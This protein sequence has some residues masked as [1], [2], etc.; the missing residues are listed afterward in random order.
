V[1]TINIKDT[2]QLSG[3]SIV[4]QNRQVTA[5]YCRWNDTDFIRQWH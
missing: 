1:G 3:R 2:I 4:F 5:Y